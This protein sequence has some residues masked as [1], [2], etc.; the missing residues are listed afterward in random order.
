MSLVLK[1]DDWKVDNL[2]G[3]EKRR[4][5]LARLLLSKP[6]ML[7]LDEPT[8]HLDLDAILWLEDFLLKFKKTIVFVTHDRAFLQRV[9]TRIVEID[10]GR[11]LSFDCDYDSYLERRQDL[12]DVEEKNWQTF[13]KKLAKEEVWIRRGVAIQPCAGADRTCPMTLIRA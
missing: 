11:L 6:D 12:L 13:D 7:L 3:G 2:S 5:A 1:G 10:R 8:N 9:A 4:I